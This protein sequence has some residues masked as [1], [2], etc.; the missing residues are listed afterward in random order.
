MIEIFLI[1][2]GLSMD[3]FAV[4]VCKGLAMPKINKKYVLTIALFFGGFQA[5]MPLLGWLLGSV[6]YVWISSIGAFISFGLLAYIGGK[7]IWDAIKEW[8][9]TE[10]DDQEPPSINLKEFFLLAF[11]TSIDAFAVG[12]TFSLF[13]VHIGLACGII[14][15]TTFVLTILA[16]YIGHLIGSKIGAPAQLVGGIILVFI[17][18]RILITS[19]L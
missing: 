18:V 17:G 6:I 12:V 4:S 8:R 10:D 7:M 15:I 1:G 14:G 2:I 9:Q 3:A 19:F 13:S 5:L 11:A 16:V